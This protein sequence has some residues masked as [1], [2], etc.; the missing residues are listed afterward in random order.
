[1]SALVLDASAAIA[2]ASPDETAPP[3]LAQAIT[4]QALAA[5]SLWPFEVYNVLLMLLRKGRLDD[6]AY[7]AS[8]AALS[9]LRVEL[10]ATSAERVVNAVSLLAQSHGLTL[11]DAAYLE[12]AKRRR[13]P[14]ATLDN[15]LIKAAKKEK[16]KL[17]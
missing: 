6:E 15:D 3:A 17:L 7:A 13:L 9:A 14:L 1:M 5:P 12:L 8:H 4:T 16:V 2:W 11:Y 10:E